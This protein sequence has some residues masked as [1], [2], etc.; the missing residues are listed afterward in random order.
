MTTQTS[1]HGNPTTATEEK[2]LNTI[3]SLEA[4]NKELSCAR[5]DLAQKTKLTVAAI[6]NIYIRKALKEVTIINFLALTLVLSFL[7]IGFDLLATSV[8]FI[9]H[10]IV[11][12][13]RSGIQ[14]AVDRLMFV[15]DT[16][17]NNFNFIGTFIHNLNFS[18]AAISALLGLTIAAA[19]IQSV[20]TFKLED[21]E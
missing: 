10:L 6:A 7:S 3:S 15:W 21:L 18:I 14:T 2:L 17:S 1:R 9:I 12:S 19:I 20:L 16:N 11:M 4:A 8:E 13:H 5:W